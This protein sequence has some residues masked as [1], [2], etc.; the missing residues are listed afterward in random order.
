MECKLKKVTSYRVPVSGVQIKSILIIGG[1]LNL[2][3]LVTGNL[4]LV[5]CNRLIEPQNIEFI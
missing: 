5:T 2:K 1:M 3:A 4:Q